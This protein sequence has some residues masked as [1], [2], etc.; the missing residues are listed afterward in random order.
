MTAVPATTSGTP[1]LPPGLPPGQGELGNDQD[2][3]K[4]KDVDMIKNDYSKNDQDGKIK[5]S[6]NKCKF[7]AEKEGG[8]KKHI[9]QTH[10]SKPGKKKKGHGIRQEG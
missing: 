2:N 8:I 10:V 1:G 5:L 4:N 7:E 6:C 9:I 3:N